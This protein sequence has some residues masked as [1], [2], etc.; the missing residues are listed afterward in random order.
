[1]VG[2]F[3]LPLAE[4]QMETGRI[5]EALENSRGALTIIARH[6]KPLS[7]RYAAAVHQRGA[8]L[9][10]ARRPAEAVPD[11]AAAVETLRQTL[12][13]RHQSRAGSRPIAALALARAGKHREAESLIDSLLPEPGSPVGP[14]ENQALYVMGVTRR[15]EGDFHSALGLLQRALDSMSPGRNADLRRMRT[16]TEI[17]LTWL[18]L[19]KPQEAAA[20]LDRALALSL[21]LQTPMAPDRADIDEGLSRAHFKQ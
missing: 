13:P 16:L 12:P 2:F 19:G 11:L 10:A 5:A 21:E 1:M 7:F 14:V 15:L 4:Y 20:S 8:A 18:D 3:S 9:L 17:G 6:T